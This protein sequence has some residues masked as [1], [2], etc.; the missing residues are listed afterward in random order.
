MNPQLNPLH[1][2][3]GPGTTWTTVN[4]GE[5]NPGV[6]TPLGL[7][8]WI[9]ASEASLVEIGHALGAYS[10]REARVS[11]VTDRRHMAGFH[12][13]MAGNVNRFRELAD[14]MPGTSGDAFEEQVLGVVQSGQR[15]NPMRRRYPV[16]AVKMP[17]AA[18]RVSA[19]LLR[20][21]SDN[22]VWWRAS[23]AAPGDDVATAVAT[24]RE[25]Y[26]RFA[27][28]MYVH[29]LVT[30]LAQACFERVT[31]LATDAGMP[32]AQSELVTG[33]GGLEE[34]RL[35]GDLWAVA[36]EG[37]SLERF[38]ANYGCHGPASGDLSSPSWRE[39]PSAVVQLLDS[40]AAMRASDG[41]LERQAR[42][43]A[44]RT[45]VESQLL[46][47]LPWHKRAAARL[48]LKLTAKFVLQREIG[49]TSYVQ[50]LDVARAGARAAGSALAREGELASG[51]DV[52][53]LTS[54]EL[55]GELPP[56][57]RE[58]IAERRVF[59]DACR[60]LRLPD[61]WRGMPAPEPQDAKD[62]F[63]REL[64]KVQGIGVA[65]GVVTGR[66]RVVTDPLADTL[67]EDGEI[68]VCETTNPSWVTLFVVA[69]ALVIDIG[70]ALSH[71]AIAARELG[72]PCVINTRDGSRRLR[73]GDTVVV[74]G[75]TGAVE[76]V[77]AAGLSESED[78][79][80]A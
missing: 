11:Q 5:A 76:L 19:E 36:R 25:A 18:W 28:M 33:Y 43:V 45:D 14:R 60:R 62:G 34:T 6:Q 66:V 16:T 40:Y 7:T 32:G 10:R 57:V 38:V 51:D 75:S 54:A 59:Y 31:S 21:R 27:R 78:V 46:A 44:R 29:G 47:A 15:N 52:F 4:F 77:G 49:K 63:E 39:D 17:Y 74:D 2:E 55:M 68:L 48:V 9:E 73:T 30:M 8:F 24:Y 61:T 23:V 69:G 35:L 58:V 67:L 41:P 80:L 79:A 42:Q 50:L 70:G 72:I 12:A 53:F 37:A 20:A 65:P 1:A 56:N 26:H 13:R 64:G 3:C 71:G 22:E